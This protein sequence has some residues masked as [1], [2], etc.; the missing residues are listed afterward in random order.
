MLK[1]T[2]LQNVFYFITLALR[3]TVCYLTIIYCT[4]ELMYPVMV[5]T[6]TNHIPNPKFKHGAN[7]YHVILQKHNSFYIYANIKREYNSLLHLSRFMVYQENSYPLGN[8]TTTPTWATPPPLPPLH[9]DAAP[10]SRCCVLDLLGIVRFP[11]NHAL[12]RF[13]DRLLA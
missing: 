6:K 4:I 5:R 11:R 1:P 12:E 3:K 9:Q 13:L 8:S 7:C 2:F 10:P